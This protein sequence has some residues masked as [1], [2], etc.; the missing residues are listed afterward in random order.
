[1][2]RPQSRLGGAKPHAKRTFRSPADAATG[3]DVH[4]MRVVPDHVQRLAV[5]GHHV[6]A[7]DGTGCERTRRV[8]LRR[9][10]SLVA[11]GVSL[12]D[13]LAAVNRE[14]AE[15]MEAD[16]TMLLR[17]EDG[18]DVT[19]VAA[20]D[21]AGARLPIGQPWS[22]DS[23]LSQVIGHPLPAGP[24]SAGWAGPF[25]AEVP[26]LGIRTC[27]SVPVQFDGRVWGASVAAWR[28]PDRLPADAEARM[29]AFLDQLTTTLVEA[30]TRCDLQLVVEEERV[31]RRMATL[32]AAGTSPS[33]II[34]RVA[35][36]TSRLLG[37]RPAAVVH[38]EAGGRARTL[39]SRGGPVAAI[40]KRA[41]AASHAVV[42]QMGRTGR[43]ARI[44]DFRVAEAAGEPATGLRGAVGAP[45][46]VGNKTWGLVLALSCD[47]PVPAGT[48]D[49]LE[50]F[51]DLIATAVANDET[52]AQL[53]AA[54]ARAVAAE[55]ESRRRI[56]RDLH[57]GAQQALI[58][59]V[60]SIAEAKATLADCDHAALANLTDA[61]AH[62]NRAIR[63]LRELVSGI[64][65]DALSHGG[66]QAGVRSLEEQICLPITVNVP[67]D[68]FPTHV[69]TTA[70]FVVAEALTNAIKHAHATGVHVAAAV[71][72]EVLELE[73]RDDGAGGADPARG[74]GLA[75][76]ADRV[77]CLG[78]T[79][80]VTSPPGAGTTLVVRLP[81]H[82]ID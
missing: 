3:A 25:A 66:L 17:V 68:R 31:L 62:A 76:L 39:A 24:A 33:A 36:E 1:M 32:V 79:I 50:A 48:E 69:E 44:D 47:G 10:A 21:L 7:V 12:D 77:A 75:G 59:T 55:D 27:V 64:M 38:F 78:G 71:R 8:A 41:L 37:G 65:P 73:V 67:P 51:A 9:V 13:L 34:E 6:P 26:R 58:L 49:R 15:L 16:A 28:S 42:A 19:R 20:W 45:I 57:D 53:V 82:T 30:Q 63:A 61:D 52:R 81:I 60:L 14:V 56:Q 2:T 43:P 35:T 74:T 4:T 5:L 54:R 70:Y 40:D 18:G 80:T 29:A 46:S 11:R 22:A 23:A 72:G